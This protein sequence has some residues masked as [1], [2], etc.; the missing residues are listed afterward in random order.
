MYLKK[1]YTGIQIFI[2]CFITL[3]L[4]SQ[5][6]LN[7]PAVYKNIQTA[8]NSVKEGDTILVQ[9]GQYFENLRWPKIN[10]IKLIS[11]G[12][13]QNT[14]IDGKGIGRVIYISTSGGQ[15]TIDSTT[16]IQGFTITN[17]Y[18][19]EQG[20]RGYGAGIYIE[21]ASPILK[22]LV[23]HKNISSGDWCF[24]GGIYLRESN[25]FIED[26]EVT[27]NILE[28]TSYSYGAGIYISESS[29]PIIKNALISKNK[30][31]SG[32]IWNYGG[33]IHI[34]D[35]S[36]VKLINSVISLNEM[37]GNN[38]ELFYGVGISCE[39]F[40]P[41]PSIE[42]INCTI[43]NNYSS[44]NAFIEGGG[45]YLEDADAKIVNSILW[46]NGGSEIVNDNFIKIGNLEV[47]FSNVEGGW[48]G[49]GN[50]NA[51]PLFIT[52]DSYFL[53]LE[54]PCLGAGTLINAP[55][56]DLYGNPRPSPIRS[57]PDMGAI[58]MDQ[59]FA[60]VLAVVYY[61][62]NQNG[63]FDQGEH[64]QQDGSIEVFPSKQI[65]LY[66]NANGILAI[67]KTGT[68][69]FEFNP[70]SLPNW[71]LTS[72]TSSYDIDVKTKNFADTIYFGVAPLDFFSELTT[73][74]YSPPLRCN[75][76]IKFSVF[77]KNQG[78]QIEDGIL[79]FTIDERLSSLNF[80]DKPDTIISPNTYG[81][82]YSDLYPGEGLMKCVKI[83]IPGITEIAAGE[84]IHF[85]SYIEEPDNT[86]KW[87]SNL[88]CYDLPQRCSVDPNDKMVN[89]MRANNYTLF[90]ED[91]IYTIRFQNTGNDLAY[92]VIVIDTLDPK[93]D[94]SSLQVLSSSHPDQL[95][96]DITDNGIVTFLFDNIRLPYEKQD[97]DGSNGFVCFKIKSIAHVPE[98]SQIQNTASI[99]FDYNP[100]IRTNTTHSVMVEK[101]PTGNTQF[102][103]NQLGIKLFPNP[104]SNYLKVHSNLDKPI[105]YVLYT[106]QGIAI[107]QGVFTNTC[108]LNLESIQSG[109]YFM[110]FRSSN[111]IERLKI[112]VSKIR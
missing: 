10:G 71:H 30:I 1:F 97:K 79:W 93:L 80:L 12:T 37:N 56:N 105:K 7:V 24:G 13:P 84:L 65:L 74:I 39:G 20:I 34:E 66:N 92:R 49:S 31:K 62:E 72:G 61:D 18:A 5:S 11:A 54:S 106:H 67:L 51:D 101:L 53:K 73:T 68:Y 40:F 102:Q 110:E 26:V 76:T 16:L 91:M 55:Q 9:P 86:F 42:I 44:D 100:S 98:Q 104:A 85:K 52:N 82:Y 6:V 32:A 57:N 75:E 28:S 103:E 59:D 14:I 19:R 69:R 111:D 22:N 33:G 107:N 25:S 108:E 3:D 2:V 43:V 29:N 88:F 95:V 112:S 4:Y 15:I 90:D 70:L 23:V 83:K 8:L 87:K 27:E 50:I 21:F 48:L 41:R 17:G 63:Q 64:I 99:Y 109:S 47:S 81:W 46:N 77:I 94:W 38:R 60:H 35:N 78:S 36:H 96:T 45:L 89:P 58:E